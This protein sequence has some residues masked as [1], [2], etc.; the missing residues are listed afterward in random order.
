MGGGTAPWNNPDT[1]AAWDQHAADT[2]YYYWEQYSYWASQGWTTEGSSCNGN[3]GEEVAAGG[4][5]EGTGADSQEKGGEVSALHDDVEVLNDLLAQTCSVEAG[6]SQINRL[7]VSAADPREE[8]V[9]SSHPPADGGHGGKRPAASSQGDGAKHAGV[10][11]STF[12]M[13]PLT[14]QRSAVSQCNVL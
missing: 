2:Y 13:L 14:L 3:T 12:L 8:D 7:F 10:C 11:A 5:D 4:A 1:K 9:S 6:G